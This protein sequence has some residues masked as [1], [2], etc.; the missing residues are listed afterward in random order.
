MK[1][2]LATDPG[3]PLPSA[4]PKNPSSPLVSLAGTSAVR[5]VVNTAFHVHAR[6]RTAGDRRTRPASNPGAGLLHLVR[7]ARKPGSAATT[8]SAR[9]APSPTSRRPSRCATYE[10]LWDDYLEVQLPGLRQPDLAGPHPLPGADQRH[11][12][13]GDEVHPRLA[14]DGRLEPQ[15]RA[16]DGGV[17]PGRPARLAALPRPALL[18]GR[19][20]R[21][22][23]TR[24]GRPP[25][26]PERDRRDRAV[27]SFSGPTRSR[28]WSW[29]SSPNWD[30]KLALLAERSLGQPIT[31]VS[32]V[33]SW[34]LVLFQRLLDLSGKST[35]GEVWPEPG[36]RRPRRRQVRPVPRG[37]R[38]GPRAAGYPAPGDL[39]LLRGVHRLRRP[40]NGPPAA[41]PRPRALLRVRPGR[42]AG[43]RPVPT[44]HWLGT[45]ETGRQ[46][47][48][49]RLDLRGHVG[50]RHRRHRPVRVARPAAPPFHRTDQVHALGL[51]RAPDQRGDRGGHRRGVGGVG[52]LVRDW[53]VGP[54]FEE[55]LGYHQYVVEFLEGPGDADRFRRLLDADLSR[56]NADYQAHRAEGVGLPLPA[57]CWLGRDRST[58][59]CGRAASSAGRTRSRAWTVPAP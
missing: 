47:R 13:G 12:A 9:S 35:I 54:V 51:R 42:R 36:G 59:G 40:A 15:G 29:R 16:D 4:R 2:T 52:R 46:L 3:T 34:L 56:R 6:L 8:A 57:S 25:G 32:G 31:L 45:A 26:G 20:D 55:P 11:D 5:R 22:G 21:P 14:R 10:E 44:R 43:L 24:A 41:G 1:P 50:A 33:P 39:S 38:A 19:L 18:P 58:P 30:R 48:D 17:S 23:R 28:P 7:K 37:V 53:H 27:A 49:R